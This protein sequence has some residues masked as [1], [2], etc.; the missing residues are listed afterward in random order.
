MSVG[1]RIKNFQ[2][3]LPT[4]KKPNEQIYESGAYLKISLYIGKN[5]LLLKNNENSQTDLFSRNYCKI[6]NMR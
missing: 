2:S 3:R 6:F 4:E 1:M 5:I